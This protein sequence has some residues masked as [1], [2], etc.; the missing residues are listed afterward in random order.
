MSGGRR[1]PTWPSAAPGR[2]RWAARSGWRVTGARASSTPR[3]RVAALL[4]SGSFR[5]LGTLVGDVP[6]DAFIAGSGVI[7]GR[8]V[9][10]GAE[11]FTVV[12]GT[13]ATGSNAKR[14]RL[15]ELALQEHVPLVMMLEGA[16]FR[17][18]ERSHGRSMTDLVMQARCSG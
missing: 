15:A 4:D 12:A 1:S 3:A 7:A 14:L 18:T 13:I 10:V 8:P 17:P 2:G 11:D 9:M 6:A 16:G 5:E